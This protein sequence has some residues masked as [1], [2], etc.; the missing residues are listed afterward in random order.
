MRV[1][2]DMSTHVSRMKA[3]GDTPGLRQG[4]LEIMP[5]QPAEEV[6]CTIGPLMLNFCT[7]LASSDSVRSM[8]PQL[9]STLHV[10]TISD[11]NIE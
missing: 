10:L 2:A 4:S 8:P 3:R 6:G 5:L 7:L 11:R 9:I 1:H